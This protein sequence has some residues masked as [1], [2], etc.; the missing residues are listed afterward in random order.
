MTHTLNDI[1]KEIQRTID[2]NTNITEKIRIKKDMLAL[3]KQ[4]IEDLYLEQDRNN[5][6]LIK[7]YDKKN[8]Q[9]GPS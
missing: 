7:L 2:L 1:E 8:K 4:E 5:D 3:L 9:S 6:K